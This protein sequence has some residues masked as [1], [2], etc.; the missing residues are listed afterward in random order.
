MPALGQ[1]IA[2]QIAALEEIDLSRQQQHAPVRLRT[3]GQNGDVETVFGVG[4]VDEGLVVAA[5]LGIGE[6]VGAERHLVERV[7]RRG[8]KP[9]NQKPATA[10]EEPFSAPER[11][12]RLPG[13]VERR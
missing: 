13:P 9:G 2:E 3:A 7:C 12:A 8:G 5:R 10:G 4:A 11:R 6:P 1:E